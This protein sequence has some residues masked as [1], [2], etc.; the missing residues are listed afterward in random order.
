MHVP[1]TCCAGM[2]NFQISVCMATSLL[3]SDT[4]PYTTSEAEAVFD[5]YGY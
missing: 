4:K 3:S 2:T 5:M 1:G